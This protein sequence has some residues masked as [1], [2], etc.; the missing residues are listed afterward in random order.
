MHTKPLLLSVNTPQQ[1][2]RAYALSLVFL[3]IS[4][5]RKTESKY[6]WGTF[7][8]SRNKNP[9]RLCIDIWSKCLYKM[10]RILPNV[11]K[12]WRGGVGINIA[13]YVQALK[14]CIWDVSRGSVWKCGLTWSTKRKF[15][16][17]AMQTGWMLARIQTSFFWILK[18]VRSGWGNLFRTGFSI[19][20]YVSFNLFWD[21]YVIDTLIFPVKYWIHG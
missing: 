19:M 18:L 16:W 2:Q 6:I 13:K 15:K 21:L 9:I 3:C 12:K 5:Q 8:E 4:K 14:K 11:W 17:P 7:Y 1:K 10:M 20:F